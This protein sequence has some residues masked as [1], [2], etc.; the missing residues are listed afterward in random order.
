MTTPELDA[1][2]ADAEADL[3][4]LVRFDTTN[5]PGNEGP[6]IDWIASRLGDVGLTSTIVRSEGRPNLVAR[7][8]G[9]G[10][11]G[12]PLLLA[13]RRWPPPLGR[14]DSRA[15]WRT[16]PVPSPPYQRPTNGD[17]SNGYFG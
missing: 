10:A 6:A 11:G 5:P 15:R 14:A 12:G 13:E 9:T 8:E 1:L 4:T 3:R 17:S 2:V 7:I 16:S